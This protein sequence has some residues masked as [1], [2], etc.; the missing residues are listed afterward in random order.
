MFHFQHFAGRWPLPFNDLEVPWIRVV[1]RSASCSSHGSENEV[2]TFCQMIFDEKWFVILP[3]L[4]FKRYRVSQALNGHLEWYI[5]QN[6][7]DPFK[8]FSVEVRWS[9]YA[10]CERAEWSWSS[11]KPWFMQKFKLAVFQASGGRDC[12]KLLLKTGIS[13]ELWVYQPGATSK[14]WRDSSRWSGA[15]S[16]KKS[17]QTFT[18]PKK[19]VRRTPLETSRLGTAK[20]SPFVQ[21]ENY[22]NHQTSHDFL[23]FI[24]WHQD[25]A[26]RV[27][28]HEVRLGVARSKAETQA[29]H[30][31][32]ETT[33]DLSKIR[34]F[35]ALEYKKMDFLFENKPL[36]G[37]LHES[38]TFW[39]RFFVVENDLV[40]WK[41][42][43]L[44]RFFLFDVL[45]AALGMVGQSFRATRFE[46]M[47]FQEIQKKADS[48]EWKYKSM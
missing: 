16:K 41:T 9:K 14:A 32:G 12:S 26:A 20:S 10:S 31:G 25:C 11:G 34:V 19:G 6:M 35:L 38:M 5:H 1:G 39:W 28:E 47:E 30:Q 29:N 18:L 24:K 17:S 23:K 8:G 42:Q 45:G 13:G 46:G 43:L 4:H 37:T 36:Q 22:L 44:D 7:A 48:L 21:T 3:R 33:R 15:F 40:S 2:M 27:E